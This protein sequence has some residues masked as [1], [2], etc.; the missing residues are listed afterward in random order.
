MEFGWSEV[1]EGDERC[2]QL[3]AWELSQARKRLARA[4]DY[5]PGHHEGLDQ[6]GRDS[7]MGPAEEISGGKCPVCGKLIPLGKVNFCPYCGTD[8]RPYRH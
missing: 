3:D 6:E 1:S 4:L 7:V 8:V 5:R 2:P